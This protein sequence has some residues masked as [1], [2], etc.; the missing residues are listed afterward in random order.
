MKF[1]FDYFL[2]HFIVSDIEKKMYIL[3]LYEL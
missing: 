2:E 3:L 1:P